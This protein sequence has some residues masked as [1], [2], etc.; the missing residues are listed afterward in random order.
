MVVENSWNTL[1]CLL[2]D[3]VALR[4]TVSVFKTVLSQVLESSRQS[5]ETL[6]KRL[7]DTEH[8][9]EYKPSGHEFPNDGFKGICGVID[10]RESFR[11]GPGSLSL[12]IMFPI[13][14]VSH[15]LAPVQGRNAFKIS[16]IIK[17]SLTAAVASSAA[18]CT[19]VQFQKNSQFTFHSFTLSFFTI[20][21]QCFL[22]CLHFFG[23]VYTSK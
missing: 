6:Q 3:L 12:Q 4:W 2:L 8:F 13:V 11:W 1:H 7:C 5:S 23:Y 19:Q 22:H 10:F 15:S 18:I 17:V 16:L 21:L 9:L 20:L 14:T